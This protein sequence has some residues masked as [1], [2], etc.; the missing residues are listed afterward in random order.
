[1]VPA[2]VLSVAAG[3]AIELRNLLGGSPNI[4]RPVEFLL[5]DQDDTALETSHRHLTRL[6]LEQHRGELPV[7]VTCLHFS[8][9]QLLKPRTPEEKEVVS[10]LAGL[11][12]IYSAG[13]YDYLP[14]AFAT[15][16][17]KGLYS[18]LRGGGRLLLGNMVEAPDTTWLM[19]FVLDW[20]LFYRTGASMSALAAGLS[21]APATSRVVHDATGHCVFLDV[22]R[23]S[24]G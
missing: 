18:Q 8:I 17:T 4:V 3:P 2:R 19:D 1:M 21:P 16:L 6:L 7:T 14:D 5:L 9:R 10:T 15:W 23:P 12:L 22:T 24:A 13:L 11:D 20:P